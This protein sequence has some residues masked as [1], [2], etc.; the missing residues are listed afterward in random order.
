MTGTVF[1]F[2][3]LR[4]RQRDYIDWALKN[5][6]EQGVEP[7][8]VITDEA[9]TML[10]AKLKTPLQIG[11]HLVRSFEVRI[12]GGCKDGRRIDR[13]DRAVTA[14]RRPG[15]AAHPPWL[16]RQSALRTIRRQARRDPPAL[17][18]R[19]QPAATKCAPPA[20]RC[21]RRSLPAPL[22]ARSHVRLKE[23]PLRLREGA[24]EASVRLK[25]CAP[26]AALYL[27][28]DHTSLRVAT[29]ISRRS[30]SAG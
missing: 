24:S 26:E 15:A 12:R 21:D 10:A 17:A 14:D 30:A 20:C 2:G 9:A 3:G 19:P 6:L 7:D 29:A 25:Q 4:D 23:R 1:E 28:P 16:R 18:R 11:R 5:S 8:E 22:L 13:R 27:A